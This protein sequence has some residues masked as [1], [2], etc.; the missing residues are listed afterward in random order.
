M[1]LIQNGWLDLLPG[2]DPAL[3]DF[4]FREVHRTDV[5]SEQRGLEQML[6]DKYQPPLNKI[7]PISPTNPKIDEY[8]DAARL[9]LGGK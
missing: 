5:R 6:H 9:Y 2:R 4:R 8:M 7:R 1:L 3:I